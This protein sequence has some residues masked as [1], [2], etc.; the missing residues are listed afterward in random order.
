M[1]VVKIDE[2]L[3]DQIDKSCVQDKTRLQEILSK[4]KY[5]TF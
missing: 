5:A 3:K 4:A 1:K 2:E